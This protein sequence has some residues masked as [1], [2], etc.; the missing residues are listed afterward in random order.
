MKE[1]H[2]EPQ[3]P[4]VAKGDKSAA[5]ETRATQTLSQ[6]ECLWDKHAPS[7][8]IKC[9]HRRAHI[10]QGTGIKLIP[11]QYPCGTRTR[12]DMPSG[13]GRKVCSRGVETEWYT[14]RPCGWPS[15][16]A[17]CVSVTFSSPATERRGDGW[18]ETEEG[19]A[20]GLKA[21]RAQCHQFD[22]CTVFCVVF[23]QSLSLSLS[24]PAFVEKG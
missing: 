12:H 4:N 24:H 13:G 16:L 18:M 11:S 20:V 14:L 8:N 3:Q 22:G 21:A 6:T 23:C 19:I 17:Y 15:G 1:L 5:H 2:I 7:R 9:V 10:T